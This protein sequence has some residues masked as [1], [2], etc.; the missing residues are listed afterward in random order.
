MFFF[1]LAVLE[2]LF[3]PDVLKTSQITLR[4][5]SPA[6]V[7]ATSDE[8]TLN[9]DKS[10][11]DLQQKK[12]MQAIQ[13]TIDSL[14]YYKNYVRNDVTRLYFPGNN[15]KYFDKLFALMENGSKNEVI[16]IMHYGDS[17]I[18]MDRISSLFRQ[19]LQDQFGGMGAGIVPPI[20]TIPSFTV[21]QSYA[22]DLQRMSLTATLPNPVHPTGVM[23]CWPLLLNFIQMPRF[24][25]VPVTTKKP[26]KNL[27]LFNV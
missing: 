12:N 20:Q 7:F 1:L 18:E 4:F 17:Q 15:Y 21:W 3:P 26:P 9:V 2:V 13:S 14:K 11:H 8:E 24:R 10:V 22:G 25:W 19:R 23:V 16:H 27:K 6:A 5:P